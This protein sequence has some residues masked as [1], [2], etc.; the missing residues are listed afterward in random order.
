MSEFYRV[1]KP[2]G[3]VV[4]VTLTEGATPLSRLVI[5]AWKLVYSVR[6]ISCGGCRP[7][8]I[9]NLVQDAAFTLLSQDVVVQMGVPSPP[10]TDHAARATAAVGRIRTGEAKNEELTVQATSLWAGLLYAR[11]AYGEICSAST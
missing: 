2:A 1:L 8:E 6:T 3:R 11:A 7:L 4:L 10:P 9:A 5:A